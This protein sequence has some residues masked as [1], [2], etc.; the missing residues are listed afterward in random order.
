MGGEPTGYVVCVDMK[1]T[2]KNSA[3]GVQEKSQ[4][5]CSFAAPLYLHGEHG[6]ARAA[7]AAAARRR[8]GAAQREI[9]RP[10]R[11]V[12]Q[13]RDRVRQARDGREP[14]AGETSRSGSVSYDWRHPPAGAGCAAQRPWRGAETTCLVV[15]FPIARLRPAAASPTAASRPATRKRRLSAAPAGGRRLRRPDRS[16][17]MSTPFET[18]LRSKW[19]A[20]STASQPARYRRRGVSAAYARVRPAQHEPRRSPH[21]S[22]QVQQRWRTRFNELE[23]IYKSLRLGDEDLLNGAERREARPTDAPP[24]AA[25]R[26]QAYP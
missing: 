1:I 18:G 19:R 15:H 17:P 16:R 4:E 8:A 23:A 6:A 5:P 21:A 10:P 24:R 3:R 13:L 7:A 25:A 20:W 9:A 22:G 11:P 26:R 12:S 2:T 14:A